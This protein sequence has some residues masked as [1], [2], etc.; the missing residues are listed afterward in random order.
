MVRSYRLG[1]MV[2]TVAGR[3]PGIAASR[4]LETCGPVANPENVA[5]A[6]SAFPGST[7]I[8]V[9]AAA[10]KTFTATDGCPASVR[11]ARAI[12][13]KDLAVVVADINAT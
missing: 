9:T 5:Y 8:R 12:G 11:R 2:Q 4:C 1:S 10:G 3:R 7:A 6:V 13:H